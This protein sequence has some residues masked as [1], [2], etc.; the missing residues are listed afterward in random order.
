MSRAF[1]VPIGHGQ[2]VSI[3]I[4][5]P[6]LRAQQLSLQTWTSSFVLARQLHTLDVQPSR[7]SSLPILELGSGT[8]LVGLTA[9]TV[10]ETPV[11]LTDLAPLLPGIAANIALNLKCT[12]NRVNCGSL[13]WDSPEL[14]SLEDGSTLT[15]AKD[16][17]SVILAADTIYSEEHPELLSRTILRWLTPGPL[18][19]VIIAYPLRVAYLDHLRE[20]WQLLEAGGLEAI[21]EGKEQADVKDWDDECLIEWC[22]WRWKSDNNVSQ[23]P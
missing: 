8:G 20:L 15:P 14:L 19:R 1:E 17:A 9:A 13:D 3:R 21:E 11:C 4:T 6:E 16:P 22:V 12:G 23:R 18:A 10:W 5:E 2:T 7:S